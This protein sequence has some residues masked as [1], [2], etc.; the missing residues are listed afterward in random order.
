MAYQKIL[1]PLDGSELAEKALPYTKTIAKL[2]NS[3]V[4]LF[5]VSITT[6]GSR[7]TRLLK[8]YIDVSAKNFKTKGIKVS[9]AIAYA[10]VADEIIEYADRN[11]MELIIIST[12]GYSGIKRWMLG[13]V[14]KK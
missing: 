14:T 11:K 12:H 10:D 1:V 5:A 7:R 2:K 3:E 13:S 8:T 9:T 6:P 4:V